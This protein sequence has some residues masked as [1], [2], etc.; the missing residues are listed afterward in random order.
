MNEAPGKDPNSSNDPLL[1]HDV[2]KLTIWRELF[3]L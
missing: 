2:T 3:V 1:C